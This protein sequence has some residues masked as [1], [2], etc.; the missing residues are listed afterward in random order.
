MHL[1]PFSF[2]A[3]LTLRLVPI[4]AIP[5]V[6]GGCSVGGGGA[7][8]ETEPRIEHQPISVFSNNVL[9]IDATQLDGTRIQLNTLRDAE[10]TTPYPP[11]MPGY[12]GR[13]WTLLK[14][15]A[16]S[17]SMGYAIV[18]WNDD[19]PGDYL[20]AGWWIHF[21]NQRYPGIDPYHPD[22]RIYVF[23][24]GPETD[25]RLQTA[26][27]VEGTASY[28]GGAGGR[29]LYRY[30]DDW[31]D[32]KG[33]TSSEEFAGVVTLKAD[34]GAG[35]MERCLGCE[36]DIRVQRRHLASAFERFETEPVELLVDPGD[37]EVRFAP[38]GFNPDGT[39]EAAEG[40][41]VGHPE[42]SI[43]EVRHGFWGGAFS[44]R[45]DGEDNPRLVVG[46]GSVQFVEQDGSASSITG[47]FNALS[48]DFRAANPRER[49]GNGSQPGGG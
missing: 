28:S 24:D 26:L 15:G 14:T 44:N 25:P 4:L 33:K 39:F 12:S 29:F 41:T 22:S 17:A 16:D 49:H 45:R 38:T 8:E 5:L 43:A 11:A 13:A 9:T 40:V 19:D 7:G 3:A 32:A 34:F 23:I 47:I 20:S 48:E 6:I 42:R 31:G 36:G 37:Y 21:G 46:Y 30:G 2:P 27:P 1:I 35:T 10:S 18:N